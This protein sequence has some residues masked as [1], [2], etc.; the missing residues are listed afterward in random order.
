MKII[1]LTGGI[2]SGKS[3]AGRMIR[4]AGVDVIDADVLA[5]EVVLPQ[6]ATWQAVVDAFGAGVV[7]ADGGLDRKALGAIVFG[8][9]AAR[10]RLNAIV[11]PAIA[12][13][14]QDKLA[15]VRDAG[16]SVVV[17]EAPLLFE[18]NLDA[19][20]DATILIAVPDDVQRARVMAR[21]QLDDA[22]A[23]ARI[24]SQMPQDEKRKRATH[25]VDNDADLATL[26]ARLSVAFSAAVGATFVLAPTT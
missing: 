16:K 12:Q 26:A 11:H 25:V 24:A 15:A 22:A 3:T 6:T 19:M 18:N 23:R 21:D 10:R 2:A 8:D 13:L 7:G 4:G 14:A 1:G 9:A 5:R 17:Y 20:C